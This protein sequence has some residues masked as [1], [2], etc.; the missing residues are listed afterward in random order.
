MACEEAILATDLVAAIPTEAGKPT[1]SRMRAR[2]R[3]AMR[4]GVPRRRRAPD[5]SRKASSM[6]TCSR[7]GVT[8][9]RISMTWQE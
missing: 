7:S 6:E 3:R 9:A 2:M 5:T 8:V 4:V 1:L